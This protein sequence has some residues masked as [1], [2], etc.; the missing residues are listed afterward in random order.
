MLISLSLLSRRTEDDDEE[1][2]TALVETLRPPMNAQSQE[3]KRYMVETVVPVIQR[4]KEV[5]EVLEDEG[6]FGIRGSSSQR[7]HPV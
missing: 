5:H 3:L 2:I 7:I 6:L 4:V 1:D